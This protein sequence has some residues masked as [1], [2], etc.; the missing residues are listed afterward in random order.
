MK[1]SQR[2]RSRWACAVPWAVDE[3]AA[4]EVSASPRPSVLSS[5]RSNQTPSCPM[6]HAVDA[7][8]RLDLCSRL[9]LGSWVWL[10]QVSEGGRSL[11]SGA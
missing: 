3:A 10:P 1:A 7:V 2:I 9:T 4:F 8:K 5:Q 11:T 6:V